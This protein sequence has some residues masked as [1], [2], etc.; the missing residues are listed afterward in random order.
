MWKISKVPVAFP[1]NDL[2]LFKVLWCHLGF[3]FPPLF[4]D[5][6]KLNRK[7]KSV[8]NA[9]CVLCFVE[10]GLSKLVFSFGSWWFIRV[11]VSH[12]DLRFLIGDASSFAF[13]LKM[14]GGL[15][16][17]CGLI[18]VV[19]IQSQPCWEQDTKLWCLINVGNVRSAGWSDRTGKLNVYLQADVW[20]ELV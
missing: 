13:S 19:Q 10:E 9:D 11:C 5:C 2:N 3:F 8:Q 6:Y 14:L 20:M 12:S 1:L 15:L 7:R 17:L 16:W 18:C 4:S